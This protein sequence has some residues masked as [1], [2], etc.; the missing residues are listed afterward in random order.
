MSSTAAPGDWLLL[1]LDRLP[2][3]LAHVEQGL[4][5]STVLPGPGRGASQFARSSRS[6]GS[7]IEPS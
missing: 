7:A 3:S 4:F 1:H 6:S 2:W 5:G